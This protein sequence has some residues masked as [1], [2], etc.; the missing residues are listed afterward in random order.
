MESGIFVGVKK[1]WQSFNLLDAN[2]YMNQIQLKQIKNA[3]GFIGA[4]D[5]SGGSTPQSL[6]AYGIESW[7]DDEEMDRLIQE[8]RLRML[9]TPA[10]SKPEMIGLILNEMM[11]HCEVEGVRVPDLLWDKRRMVPFLKV[12]RGLQE[13]QNGVQLMNDFPNLHTYLEEAKSYN[14][15]G[16]KMRSVIFEANEIGIRDIIVQQFEWGQIILEHD[17]IPILEPEID[18]NAVH[19]EE[20]ESILKQEI[21]RHLD[22]IKQPI[23][24]KLTLPTL[25][26]FYKDLVHHPMVLRV[27][28]LSGGYSK[29]YAT[30]LLSR[31]QGIISAFSRV[32]AE[33]LNVHQSDKEFDETLSKTIDELYE[34]SQK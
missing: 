33:G 16:T 25:D 5:H 8:F 13:Q 12:D 4:L 29:Q 32:L 14:I 9:M 6:R 26:N 23:M 10:F 22:L 2:Y 27:V 21:L 7:A 18:I 15:F 11:M 31:N 1:V 3:R 19:K 30:E 24:L 34:A 28:A 20:A 17:L